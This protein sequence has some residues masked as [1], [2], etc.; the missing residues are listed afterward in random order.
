MAWCGWPQ[1]PSPRHMSVSMYGNGNHSV[2]LQLLQGLYCLRPHGSSMVRAYQSRWSQALPGLQSSPPKGT[3]CQL[4]GLSSL[5][6]TVATKP[7]NYHFSS[8]HARKFLQ[9]L[10]ISRH[11]FASVFD[12]PPCWGA[13]KRPG[14]TAPTNAHPIGWHHGLL[15]SIRPCVRVRQTQHPSS[16]VGPALV[17]SRRQ[18]HRRCGTSANPITKCLLPCFYAVLHGSSVHQPSRPTAAFLSQPLTQPSLGT[19]YPGSAAGAN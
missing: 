4:L 6:N 5:G 19:R 2:S 8:T 13:K 1:A 14:V 10:Q 15:P 3:C 9:N 18:P 11:G 12:Q 17:S 7:H 16:H